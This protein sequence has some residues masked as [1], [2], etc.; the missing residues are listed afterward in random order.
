[1]ECIQ[2][3]LT[4]IVKSLVILSDQRCSKEVGD[5]QFGGKKNSEEE[6]KVCKGVQVD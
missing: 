2:E 4:Q 5:V 6:V 1:M 3:A